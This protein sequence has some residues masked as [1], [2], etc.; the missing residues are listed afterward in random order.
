MTGTG[1]A[2]VLEEFGAKMEVKEYPVPSAEPG[3][4]VVEIDVAT[5][6]GSDLHIWKGELGATYSVPM[7]L[8]IGHEMV[9]R[10]VALGEGA[11]RDSAGTS[12]AVGDRVVW[13]NEPC[14]HCYTCTVEREL[15]L[16][17]NRRMAGLID[18][19]VAPHFHG[20]FAEYGYVS[21]GS[22][23]LR[24]PDEVESAW[25]SAGSCALRTVIN[26]VEAAGW[27]DFLDSVVVQG[28]GPLG[29]FTVALMSLH[30]PKHLIVV[31]APNERLELA[32][33]WG[34]T[35]AISIEETSDPVARRDEV[36]AITGRGGPSVAIE[37][38]GARGAAAEGVD[39][40]RPN[41]RYVISGT[42][43]GARQEI[44]VARVTTR[45][46]HLTGSMSGDIDAYYK[47]LE[48][49]GHHRDRFDWDMMLGR[50][51][52]LHE[53]NDALDAMQRMEQIKPIVDPS[54]N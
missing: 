49:L 31:G 15:T 32:R 2:A 26:T 5:V 37:V 53:V 29:L 6:C 44:D 41:G 22:G 10:I 24:V 27:V 54:L 48:F 13:A 28:A 16:C 46:L 33:A 34:A 40:M 52:G 25:A 21:P 35:H 8:I 3:A 36:H 1:R 4:L 23:R 12:L 14:R 50:R 11:E 38:S 43:G 9:G 19:S 45:G 30:S 17:M 47:A 18:C 42:V 39:M 7:P 51:Y 20:A